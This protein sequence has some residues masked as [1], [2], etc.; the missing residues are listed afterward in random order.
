[1]SRPRGRATE[2]HGGGGGGNGGG[3]GGGR[4]GRVGEGSS[5]FSHKQVC[6][7]IPPKEHPVKLP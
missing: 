7:P 2:I 6:L 5:K 3:Y 1:M 4:A